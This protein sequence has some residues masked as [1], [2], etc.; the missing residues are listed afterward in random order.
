[1]ANRT[2]QCHPFAALSLQAPFLRAVAWPSSNNTKPDA[3][4]HRSGRQ[5]GAAAG[6][7]FFNAALDVLGIPEVMLGVSIR[8]IEVQQ[9]D[10]LLFRRMSADPSTRAASHVL[11]V[12]GI[13]NRNS[14]FTDQIHANGA[15]TKAMMNSAITRTAGITSSFS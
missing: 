1:V 8:P 12:N 14:V 10:H 4:Y 9:V 15:R 5:L 3:R 7:V 11:N 13:A 2:T 6:T